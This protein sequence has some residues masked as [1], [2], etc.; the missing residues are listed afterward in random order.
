MNLLQTWLNYLL[1]YKQVYPREAF[2]ERRIFGIV[3]YTASAS[4]LKTYLN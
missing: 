3:V 4:A 2:A 1:Y